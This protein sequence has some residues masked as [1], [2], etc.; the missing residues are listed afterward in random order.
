M[1][2]NRNNRYNNNSNQEYQEYQEEEY[3][4]RAPS[5]S[6]YGQ[7]PRPNGPSSGSQYGQSPQPGNQNPPTLG[8]QQGQQQPGR[9]NSAFS[10]ASNSPAPG[11][12]GQRPDTIP[13]NYSSSPQPRP[14]F[15]PMPN[16]P[17]TGYNAGMP[18]RPNVNP[19]PYNNNSPGVNSPAYN[20]S[21]GMNS[22]AFNNSPNMGSKP[23]MPGGN[24]QSNMVS[25]GSYTQQQIDAS[26]KDADKKKWMGIAAGSVLGLGAAAAATA[27]IYA[28]ANK[29]KNDDNTE[30]HQ[31]NNND[32]K[33]E[34]F[35]GGNNSPGNNSNQ[36]HNQHNNNNNNQYNN[37]NQQNNHGNHHESHNNSYNNNNNCSNNDFI[38]SE[39]S[40]TPHEYPMLRQNN[41]DPEIKIGTVIALKHNMTGRFLNSNPSKISVTGSNQQMVFCYRWN[42]VDYD[43]WQVIPANR[44]VIPPGTKVTYGSTIRLRHVSSSRHL[45]SHTSHQCPK[46]GQN[47]VT[48]FGDKSYSDSNDHWIVEPFGYDKRHGQVWNTND[49]VIFRHQQTGKT[50]HSHDVLYS[51]DIQSVTT[52]GNGDDENDKWRI[53]LT[54]N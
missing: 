33:N 4:S 39:G 43:W 32:H 46:T 15:V 31:N 5:A 28:L 25:S 34:N 42:I 48:C 40:P 45:H 2:Y 22:P 3:G 26:K 17:P 16:A 18:N 10:S 13:P 19:P 53:H 27:G 7:A 24:L 9:P 54:A 29:N 11:Y 12:N 51:E 37:N 20:N 44:D 1:D 41:S 14:G 36:H 35:Y 38:T 52:Y 8:F 30:E 49:A 47:E 6:V 21:P 50:L 23:N